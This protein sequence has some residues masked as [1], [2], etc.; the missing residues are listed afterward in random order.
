MTSCEKLPEV[1][2]EEYFKTL[3]SIKEWENEG[4]DCTALKEYIKPLFNK[5]ER[6]NI[7]YGLGE[8]P[9]K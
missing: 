5:F 4:V 3:A 1:D 9:P 6:V 8:I 7:D 2:R